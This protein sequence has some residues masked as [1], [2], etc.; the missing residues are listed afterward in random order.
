MKQSS[1][2]VTLILTNAKGSYAFAPE[3]IIRLKAKSNYTFIFPVDHKPFVVPRVLKDYQL[4]LEPYG[5]IRTHRSHIVNTNLIQSVDS[6]TITMQDASVAE[7]SR[8]QKT[9]V[10]KMLCRRA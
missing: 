3:Q 1:A 7:I 2:T 8:R 6:E 9:K 5:F 4:M 10:M